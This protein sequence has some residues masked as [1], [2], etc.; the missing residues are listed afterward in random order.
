MSGCVTVTGPPDLVWLRN[1]GTADPED[2]NPTPKR[3][4][5]NRVRL[6]KSIS[7]GSP[8]RLGWDSHASACNTSSAMRLVQPMVLVGRTAL[9]VEISTKLVTPARSAA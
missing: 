9:S 8:Y 1:R 6:G 4:M 5:V 2:P 3:T 7:G